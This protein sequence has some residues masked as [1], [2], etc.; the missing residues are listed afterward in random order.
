MTASLTALLLRR[1][2]AAGPALLWGRQARPHFGVAFDSLLERGV[3]VELAPATEWP[4]CPTCECGMAARIIRD[5]NGQL[6]ALCP[7]D[8]N[9]D[10]VL[11]HDD[12][13]DFRIEP[14]RLVAEL[15]EAT[16]FAAPVEALAPGLWRIGRLP[17]GRCVVV[18]L[19][20]TALDQPGIVLLLKT[21][22]GGA[23]VT[24]LAPGPGPAIRLRFLEA[25]VHL[26]D[27][28]AAL[29]PTGGAIDQLDR[30]ML[31]PG[32]AGPRLVLERRARR[33]S[34]DGRGIRLSE[35]LFALLLF[36]AERALESPRTVDF[37]AIEDHVW[38]AGIH[39]IASGIREPIRALRDA[40]A[41][42][43]EDRNAARALIENARN[44]NGY[45]LDLPATEIAIAD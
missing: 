17:S 12:L 36:L 38:G 6:R 27:L 15:A 3:L 18:G 9:C 22:A 43:A 32:P 39:R 23:P 2:E 5:I 26:V 4:V 30:V 45:R 11:D 42:D 14:E 25:G 19:T 34:L 21:T 10:D 31:D 40:L 20:C 33:A 13:R 1:S 35:Q 44:P 41:A 24:V 37:R 16:G 8:P 7:L 28:R 29:N